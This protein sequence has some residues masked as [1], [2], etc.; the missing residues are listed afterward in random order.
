MPDPKSKYWLPVRETMD[1]GIREQ[2]ILERVQEVMTYAYKKSVFYR[3][4]WDEAGVHPEHI[5]SLDDFE[6][7]PV[8][9]KQEL[10]AAQLRVEPFGDYLCVPERE[11]HHIHGTS[12]TTGRNSMADEMRQVFLP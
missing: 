10:R 9:T 11:V 7:V 8:V 2:K 3:N 6:R 4:K 5:S 12:G 1:P